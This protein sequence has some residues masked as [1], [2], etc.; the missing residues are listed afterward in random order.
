M[1]HELLDRGIA[2]TY[3]GEAWSDNCREWAYFDCYIRSSMPTR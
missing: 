3:R 1:I 2:I